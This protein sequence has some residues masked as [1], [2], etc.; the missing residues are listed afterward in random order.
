MSRHYGH[1]DPSYG[2]D[3]EGPKQQYLNKIARLPGESDTAYNSFCGFVG[4]F[5]MNETDAPLYSDLHKIARKMAPSWRRVRY[6]PT[7]PTTP[8]VL[9]PIALEELTPESRRRH[10]KRI[11]HL[12]LGVIGVAAAGTVALMASAIHEKSPLADDTSPRAQVAQSAEY[13]RTL[14]IC[15]QDMATLQHVDEHVRDTTKKPAT[16]EEYRLRALE[17]ATAAKVARHADLPCI[18]KPDATSVDVVTG[19][20][21][22]RVTTVPFTRANMLSIVPLG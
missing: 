9:P 1:G 10:G 3:G 19:G 13:L 18:N 17:D 5:V 11:N 21:D 4:R 14:G 15:E 20:N 22:F 2:Y 12:M 6:F 7:T 8:E 16:F